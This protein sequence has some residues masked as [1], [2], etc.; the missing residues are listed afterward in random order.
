MIILLQLVEYKYYNEKS[1][2]V[3]RKHN[4]VRSYLCDG[5]ININHVR[6]KENLTNPLTKALAREQIFQTSKGMRLEP[7]EI[8]N[9]NNL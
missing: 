2:A 6:S 3:R 9:W 1:R 5:A 8:L 4:T 7:K